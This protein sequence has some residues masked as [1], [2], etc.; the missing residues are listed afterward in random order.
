VD[1]DGETTDRKQDLG[2]VA[3]TIVD[4]NAYMTLATADGSGQP[5]ASP[6][7]YANAGYREFYWVSSPETRHSRNLAARSQV[8]VVIFDS[9]APIGEGQAVYMSA[10]AGEVKGAELDRG[11]EIFSRESLAGGAPEWTREEVQPPALHRLYRATV[12]AHW[13]LDPSGHPVHGRALDH[14]ARVDL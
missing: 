4:S 8:S 14:R 10:L 6:V 7:W 13:V 1:H 11:I 5:W 3:R 12:S 2:A 9:H